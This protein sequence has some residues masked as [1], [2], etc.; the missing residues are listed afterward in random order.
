MKRFKIWYAIID[1]QTP[2]PKKKLGNEIVLA[3]NKKAALRKFSEDNSDK[4]PRL[5]P[6]LAEAV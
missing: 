2:L 4:V 3:R 1:D 6:L 5:V